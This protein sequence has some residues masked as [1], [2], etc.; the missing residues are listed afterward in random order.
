MARFWI[1]VKVLALYAVLGALC[2]WSSSS[3]SVK[4]FLLYPAY[5]ILAGA[6]CLLVLASAPAVGLFLMWRS[7]EKTPR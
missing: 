1:A 6:V 2:G 3:H 7:P 5:F 4:A